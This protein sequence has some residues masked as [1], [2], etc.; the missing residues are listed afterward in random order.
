LA[1]AAFYIQP[2][3]TGWKRGDINIKVLGAIK[4]LQIIEILNS[5]QVFYPFADTFHA[6]CSQNADARS[7]QLVYV[8]ARR[9]LHAQ[10]MGESCIRDGNRLRLNRI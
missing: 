5:V 1:I 3:K 8:D 9:K 4:V 2:E 7:I 10:E 6:G